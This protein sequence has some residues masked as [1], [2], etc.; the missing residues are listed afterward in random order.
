MFYARNM[1]QH[2]ILFF[3]WTNAMPSLCS[4]C[5][6]EPGKLIRSIWAN[7]WVIRD[8]E[9]V[10]LLDRPLFLQKPSLVFT[11]IV[12]Q[13]ISRK[14]LARYKTIQSLFTRRKINMRGKINILWFILM[15]LKLKFLLLYYDSSTFRKFTSLLRDCTVK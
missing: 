13:K 2:T 11:N 14:L 15:M 9:T 3:A 7:E 1:A 12:E 10:R 4:F 8:R 6:K 5:S